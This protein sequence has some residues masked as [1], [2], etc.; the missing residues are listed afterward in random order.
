MF[1]LVWGGFAPTPRG[2]R[3]YRFLLPMALRGIFIIKATRDRRAE[4]T[5]SEVGKYSRTSGCGGAAPS[6]IA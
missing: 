3:R 4:L 2:A 5:A 6:T 1:G